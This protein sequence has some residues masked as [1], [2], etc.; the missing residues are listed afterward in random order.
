[1]GLLE[2]QEALVGIGLH[3]RED[4]DWE[5][6]AALREIP[7]RLGRHERNPYKGNNTQP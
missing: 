6:I 5:R 3:S 1:M 4:R 2:L 7:N